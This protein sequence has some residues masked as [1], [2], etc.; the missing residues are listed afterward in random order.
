ME[1]NLVTVAQYDN[2][3]EADL[4]RSFLAENHIDSFVLN[5]N[6]SQIFPMIT[7]DMFPVELQVREED[8]A[9]ALHILETVTDSYYTQKL[10]E[11]SG[12]LLNGHFQLTSGLHSDRYVEKIKLVQDPV[13]VM[14]LCQKLAFRLKDYEADVIVGPA[15][16][17]IVLAYEVAKQLGRHFAFTQREN[18]KMVLR[19]GFSLKQHAKA[20]IIED[21]ITTGTS[22]MEVIEALKDR[23]VDVIAVGLIVDR[24]HGKVDFGVPTESLLTLDLETYEPASC[25]LCAQGMLL[26]K[27]GSSDK[28]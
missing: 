6:M 27:P 12:S 25:P 21:I 3:F 13:K 9:Q 1:K 23:N 16:G 8:E 19:S 18:D 15:Y 14:A 22:V 10:L 5:E 2:V 4:A 11:E 28:K 20:I 24:S 17:G 26:L 7:N